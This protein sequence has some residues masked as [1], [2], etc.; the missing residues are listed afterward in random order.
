MNWLVSFA[1]AAAYALAFAADIAVKAAFKLY[2][3]DTSAANWCC[4][5][6]FTPGLLGLAISLYSTN[7]RQAVREISPTLKRAY[8]YTVATVVVVMISFELVSTT[9]HRWLCSHWTSVFASDCL[10]PV[11]KPS[12]GVRTLA[13]SF[14][15]T[16]Q[17]ATATFNAPVSPEIQALKDT[18]V[19]Y[20]MLASPPPQL[21][22]HPGR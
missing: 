1:Y 21:R 15:A 10:G 8:F 19:A 18:A 7:G 4:V 11:S 12:H 6:L 14:V 5:I 13:F 2:E 17:N 16:L 9:V 22:I 3:S 20:M